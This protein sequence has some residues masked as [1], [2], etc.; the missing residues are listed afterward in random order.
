M[1]NRRFSEPVI[2]QE[3]LDIDS[4]SQILNLTSIFSPQSFNFP[5]KEEPNCQWYA[6]QPQ[7][8]TPSG[9]SYSPVVDKS[10][11]SRPQVIGGR[12]CK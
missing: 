4:S 8:L 1:A 6:A 10:P 7:G 9:P 2:K 5:V 12:V 3:P 11:L